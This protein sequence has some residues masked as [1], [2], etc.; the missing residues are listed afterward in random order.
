M[1]SAI[2]LTFPEPDVAALTFDLPGKGANILSQAVL[3]ELSAHLDALV[4]RTDLAGLVIRSGK[5]GIFIAGA[6]IRE[7]VAHQDAKREWTVEMCHRGRKLLQRLS[8]CPFVTVALIDGVS[9]GGGTELALWCDRRIMST[10]PKAQI[11]LPEVK[12]GLYPGWGGTARLPRIVGL[13]NAVEMICGGETIDG[14]AAAAM[15]LVQAAVP[16]ERLEQAAI[17]LIRAEH[18]TRDYVKDRQRWSGAIDISDTELYFLGATASAYVQQQTK[19]RYPAPLAALEMM[20]E[21]ARMDIEAA[22]QKEAEGMA[23]LFGSPVNRALINVFFLTDR[24]KKDPGVAGDVKPAPVRSLSVCGAG[25]MGTGIAA[26][27]VKREIPVILT[28][29]NPAALDKGVAAIIE[30]ASYNKAVKGPD[31][32]RALKYAPL[33]HPTASDADLAKADLVLEAIVENPDVKKKLFAR[34]E[35]LLSADAILA[36][37]TSTIPIARLA[38]DLK[39]PDRFCGIHFFNPVRKMPLVEVIRGPKT[40]DQT[41]AT[42]VAFVKAIGKTPIAVNDGP[43]FMVNRMLVAYMNEALELLLDGAAM[44]DIEKA[45]T[46]FGMPVGP[47]TLYD[48]VGIDT[49][50]YCG[51]VMYEAFPDRC[52]PSPLLV[53]MLKKQR[54]GQKVGLGFY[55]Y[56]LQAGKEGAKGEP[57]PDFDALVKPHIRSGKPPTKEEMTSRLFLPMLLEATRIL[58]DKIVRDVRDVDLGLIFGLGFPPFKGGLCFWADTL[59]AAKVLEML[60]PFEKLGARFQPTPMLLG[61]A[62]TGKKFYA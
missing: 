1:D 2:S 45:A 50:F 17:D 22:C 51:G 4:K 62:R 19:G 44:K 40:S 58:E 23:E 3:A 42:A 29:V 27:A 54:L 34:L 8:H 61:M 25:L 43:G 7:F 41:V 9:L 52:S 14:K 13:S 10:S 18:K 35:P 39:R 21:A 28:D 59:G 53:Q 47:L 37:N 56:A 30:E 36:S 32:Q 6:D 26:I 60:K 55:K 38:A 33:V 11:G 5:P 46:S 15:G 24:N 48:M 31:A 49:A 12:L 20:L 57:D 16:S